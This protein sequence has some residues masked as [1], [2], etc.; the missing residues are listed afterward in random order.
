MRRTCCLVMLVLSYNGALIIMFRYNGSRV[1]WECTTQGR[2]MLLA[3]GRMVSFSG[4]G[5]GSGVLAS[6]LLSW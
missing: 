1:G 6:D 3:S 2:E 4:E 5:Q